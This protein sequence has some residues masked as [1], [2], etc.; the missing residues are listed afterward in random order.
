MKLGTIPL[1]E[2]FDAALTATET[3]E[4]SKEIYVSGVKFNFIT[5]IG[6]LKK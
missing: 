3:L 1:F 6:Y 4:N 2:V 5:G